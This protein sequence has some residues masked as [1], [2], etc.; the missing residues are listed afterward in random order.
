MPDIKPSYSAQFRMQM[1]ELA[2][3][4][5]I[6]SGTL[7]T[8]NTAKA[9]WARLQAPQGVQY[10]IRISINLQTDSWQT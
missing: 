7:R 10:C 8:C 4:E 5:A 1:V 6:P 3:A 9:E 2:Q